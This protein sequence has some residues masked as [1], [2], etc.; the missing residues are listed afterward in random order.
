MVSEEKFKAFFSV[1]LHFGFHGNIKIEQWAYM[2]EQR[3]LKEQF[4]ESVREQGN[5]FIF[6]MSGF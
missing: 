1:F 4:Y 5:D 3:L 2:A 6:Q